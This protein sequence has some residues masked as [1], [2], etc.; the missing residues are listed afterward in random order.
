MAK[1]ENIPISF[2]QDKDGIE[3]PPFERNYSEYAQ[4]WVRTDS[5]AFLDWAELLMVRNETQSQRITGLITL[6][7]E[8]APKWLPD[9]P[10]YELIFPPEEAANGLV[11]ALW[12][13]RSEQPQPKGR[14]S[15]VESTEA[16]ADVKTYGSRVLSAAAISQVP[17][18]KPEHIITVAHTSGRDG[19]LTIEVGSGDGAFRYSRKNGARIISGLKAQAQEQQ[20]NRT[21]AELLFDVRDG[22]IVAEAANRPESSYQTITPSAFTTALRLA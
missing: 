5:E 19:S 9:L 2:G 14:H 7:H 8:L 18:R 1:Q 22:R 6:R 17:K 20:I 13:Q 16:E 11:L 4:E 3:L 12:R 10:D 15:L 21:I